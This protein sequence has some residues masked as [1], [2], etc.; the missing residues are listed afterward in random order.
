MKV[1]LDINLK[2]QA[3]RSLAELHDIKNRV[4]IAG[5]CSEFL[6]YSLELIEGLS[7]RETAVLEGKTTAHNFAKTRMQK[8]LE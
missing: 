4:L 3:E 1:E 7:T 8:W 5:Q 6:Q 2:R